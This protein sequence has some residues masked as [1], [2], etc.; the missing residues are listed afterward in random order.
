MGSGN[1][2]SV[3]EPSAPGTR[4]WTD[5][6]VISARSVVDSAHHSRFNHGAGPHRFPKIHRHRYLIDRQ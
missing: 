6:M 4:R 3:Y 1:T 5:A 2:C